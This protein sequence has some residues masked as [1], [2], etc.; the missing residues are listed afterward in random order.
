MAKVL[1][2]LSAADLLQ[3]TEGLSRLGNVFRAIVAERRR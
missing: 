1:A 3:V 2:G